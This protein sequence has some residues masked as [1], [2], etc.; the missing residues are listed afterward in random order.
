MD[1]MRGPE[2]DEF[3]IEEKS[4]RERIHPFK[5]Q[6]LWAPLIPEE[7]PGM[8]KENMANGVSQG[9]K[10]PVGEVRTTEIGTALPFIKG[11]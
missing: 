8:L 11:K 1:L 4:G 3:C 6:T 2:A 5:G 7:I 10:G 9:K